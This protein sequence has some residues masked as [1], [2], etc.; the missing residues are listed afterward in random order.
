VPAKFTAAAT[1]KEQLLLALNNNDECSPPPGLEN[2]VNL[3]CGGFHTAAVVQD[4]NMM[5]VGNGRAMCCIT[6]SWYS[7]GC[8]LRLTIYSCNN[9]K[10]IVCSEICAKCYCSGPCDLGRMFYQLWA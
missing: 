4:G 2:V 7:G 8:Q 10:E 1:D 5:C 3:A 6:S 9:V